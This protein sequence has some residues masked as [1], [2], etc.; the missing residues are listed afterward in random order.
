MNLFLTLLALVGII[1]LLR[2]IVI[3]F[4]TQRSSHYTGTT[5]AFDLREHLSGTM[6]SEGMIYGPRGHVVSR[7][8]AKMAGSWDGNAGI[9]TEDFTYA[10]SG[11][12]QARCWHLTLGKNGKFTATAPDIIGVAEGEVSGATVR[13]TYRIKLTEEAG[14]YV[15]DV[16]DWMYLMENGVIMNRSEMRK[17]GIKVAELIATIRPMPE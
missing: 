4:H 3:G 10:G 5:P 9:L 11:Q 17:F 2:G 8:A 13:L 12:T 15:L 16:T 6:L 14:G 1:F 7:F